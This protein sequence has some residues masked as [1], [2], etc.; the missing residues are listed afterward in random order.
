[1]KTIV[2]LTTVHS[3]L[4]IV[5]YTLDS[6]IEQ[7]YKPDL[8]LF[9]ISQESYLLDKGISELPD[10]L[11][12]ERY[13]DVEVNWVP[14]DGPYRK[15]LPAIPYANDEDLIVT[16]D[17]DHIY[18]PNWLS[19]LVDEANSNPESIVCGRARMPIKNIFGQYQSYINWPLM[20]SNCTS[21]NLMPTGN[22]GIVYRKNLLDL[23]FIFDENYR[24]LASTTDD[25]WFREASYR[26]GVKVVVV[27]RIAGSQVSIN[28]PNG[29][30]L[31]DQNTSFGVLQKAKGILRLGNRITR[32]IKAYFGVSLNNNDK[33]FK[34]IKNHSS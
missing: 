5:K 28:V 32:R 4:F 12:E 24:V 16:V 8:I 14:N 25:L 29:M 23:D 18:A 17:D 34:K 9:N 22:C 31:S 13:K 27:P 2:S 11:S 21:I 1:M 20:K 30:A 3:R 19:E 7:D 10:W 15:L 6:L 26:L 33:A